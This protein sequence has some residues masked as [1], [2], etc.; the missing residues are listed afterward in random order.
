MEKNSTL[1]NEK[2]LQGWKL[3][4]RKWDQNVFLESRK[5]HSKL[6]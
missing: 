1:K 2:L 5:S 4:N 6:G 3:K